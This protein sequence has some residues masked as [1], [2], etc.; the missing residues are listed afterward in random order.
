M[1]RRIKGAISLFSSNDQRVEGYDEDELRRILKDRNYH[2]P[3]FSESDAEQQEAKRNI[4]VYNPT[5]RSEEVR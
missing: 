4:N 5:W 2:S 3:E 1:G